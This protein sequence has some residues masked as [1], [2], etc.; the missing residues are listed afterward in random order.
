MDTGFRRYDG[1]EPA[2]QFGCG[3]AALR[4]CGE[5]LFG[6]LRISDF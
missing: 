1:N 5:D 3:A 6:G 4:L 2:F